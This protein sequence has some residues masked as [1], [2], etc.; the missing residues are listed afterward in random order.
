MRNHERYRFGFVMEQTLG[1]VTHYRN[2]RAAVD[3]TSGFDATWYPLTFPPRGTLETLPP[4]RGN[5]S[6][7]ASLRARRLLAR[8]ASERYDALFFHT[9]VTTLLSAGVMQ[10]V[11][12]VVSLDATPINYDA[13]GAAYGH[14]QAGGAVESLKRLLNRRSLHAAGALVTWCDWARQ[15]LIAD[16]GVDAARITVVPPGVN[17]DVWPRPSP[18]SS[19]GPARLLFVGADFARKG[20]E[21]LLHAF[22]ESL[23]EM[24]EIY[25]VTKAA[26]E[27]RPGIY[28]YRDVAP[29]SELLKRLYATADL[30]VLPTLADCFPLVIQEAMAAGLPVV[31]TDVGAIREAVRDGETGLLV[32]PGD[33]HALA[34]ALATLVADPAARQAMGVR[35]RAMAEQSFDSVANARR[36]IAIMAHL[37]AR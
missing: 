26:V 8:D 12:S 27:P 2:M 23:Q 28:V 25:L 14:Q 34:V 5:W 24:C 32:P 7:R 17:L 10:R 31:A 1:H 30:F 13:V 3:T 15:S 35:G 29:N 20:G 16:Y 11:P 19:T 4:F 6:A 22:S 36:I 9:Q 18:R 21:V 33:V 37:C